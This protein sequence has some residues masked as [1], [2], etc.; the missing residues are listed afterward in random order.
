MESEMYEE[1]EKLGAPFEDAILEHAFASG[2]F[3]DAVQ[4][5]SRVLERIKLRVES[6]L[7]MYVVEEELS[8]C[9][10]EDDDLPLKDVA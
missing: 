3:V 8:F 9:P 10:K 7:L 1:V 4:E 5:V 6:R 2:S